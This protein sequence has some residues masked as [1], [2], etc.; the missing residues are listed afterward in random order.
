MRF[1]IL[2]LVRS[3][4]FIKRNALQKFS[5]GNSQ[6]RIYIN[7]FLELIILLTNVYTRSERRYENKREKK[8]KI[9]MK[10]TKPREYFRRLFI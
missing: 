3:T 9:L 2:I 6:F 5:Q 1:L 4:T 8:K 10:F 7:S